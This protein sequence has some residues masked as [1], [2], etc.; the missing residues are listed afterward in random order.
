MLIVKL[1]AAFQAYGERGMS[2]TGNRAWSAVSVS[3]I[4][5]ILVTD[6]YFAKSMDDQEKATHLENLH[7]LEFA[8]PKL[9]TQFF[10]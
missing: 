10:Q 8:G 6:F 3:M 5:F 7:T 1:R 4:Y 2:I 9:P